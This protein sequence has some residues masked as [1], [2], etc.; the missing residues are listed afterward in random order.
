MTELEKMKAGLLFDPGDAEIIAIQAPLLDK[1]AE[2][3]RLLPS[4]MK[5]KEEYMNP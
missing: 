5:E 2:F 3:N 4:Q 1:L